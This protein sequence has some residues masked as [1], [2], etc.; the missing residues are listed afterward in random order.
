M[1]DA[2]VAAV[3]LNIF[4][5]HAD[6]VRLTA[7]AQ[8]V[9]VLQA[10]ILTD[11][12]RMVK[13]PTYYVFQLYKP[14]MDATVLPVDVKG[15]WYN[16]DQWVMPAVSASAVRGRDGI[17]RIA[18]ANVD[19]NRPA[20]VS[21]TLAGLAATQVPGQLLTAAA[22]NAPNEFGQAPGRSPGRRSRTAGSPRRYR[23]RRSWCWSC[24]EDGASMPSRRRCRPPRWRSNLCPLCRR[25]GRHR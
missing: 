25:P 18:L 20:P 7:V 6:R 16:K 13:T 5:H 11:G 15:R 24:D 21:A 23:P 22:I 19:P 17:V 12:P 2:L 8:M 1:R 10:M 4:A 9:N 14:W 3:H